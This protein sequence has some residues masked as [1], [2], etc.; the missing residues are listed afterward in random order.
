MYTSP[1]TLASAE[2]CVV[3]GEWGKALDIY[4]LVGWRLFQGKDEHVVQMQTMLSKAGYFEH[5][6]DGRPSAEIC[7]AL[8]RLQSDNGLAVDRRVGPMTATA[9]YGLAYRQRL[10][11][12]KDQHPTFDE[13]R[14][15]VK[16]FQVRN[17]LNPDGLVGA[18][19]RTALT[20]QP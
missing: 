9:L 1:A 13:L 14:E 2:A 5:E 16:A 18:K 20:G 7:R 8:E 6:A 11:F 19:T 10:G 3:S 15:A 17:D 12:S 4:N